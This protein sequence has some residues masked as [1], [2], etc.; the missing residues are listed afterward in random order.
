ML[1]GKCVLYLWVVENIRPGFLPV[2]VV[3]VDNLMI[4]VAVVHFAG[5][6]QC[7]GGHKLV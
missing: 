5:T 2:R 3:S 1:V 6:H 7:W 4:R